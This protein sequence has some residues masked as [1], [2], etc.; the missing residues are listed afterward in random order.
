MSL[1]QGSRR[2]IV[3]LQAILILAMLLVPAAAITMVPLSFKLEN[4][5]DQSPAAKITSLHHKNGSTVRDLVST[6]PVVWYWLT[7]DPTE[8]TNIVSQSVSG[9]RLTETRISERA[10]GNDYQRPKEPGDAHYGMSLTTNGRDR[11]SRLGQRKLRVFLA[12][13]VLCR[14]RGHN[15]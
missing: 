9:G 6:E 14:V 2:R 3:A 7:D 1:V 15:P 13:A 4:P 10:F 12:L 5:L 11:L 8:L